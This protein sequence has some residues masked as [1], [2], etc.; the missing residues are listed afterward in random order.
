M[1]LKKLGLVLGREQFQ[2]FSTH[3]QVPTAFVLERVVR[4]FY[5]ARNSRGKSFTTFVDLDRSNPLE[6]VYHHKKP[7]FD[8]GKPGTFDEDGVMPSEILP[9]AGGIWL[10]YSGWNQKVSTPYHNSMGL[11]FSADQGRT[12]TRVYEGPIF[13]RNHLEPYVTVTPTL[14]KIGD[15][16]KMWYVSG[17][18]WLE[19]NGRREPLYVIKSAT[20]K[21]GILWQRPAL[22]VIPSKFELEAFSRPSVFQGDQNLHM[23][24]CSRGSE[25]YRDGSQGY[26]L[27]YAVSKDLGETW[28]RSD[29]SLIVDEPTGAWEDRMN[30]Y[31]YHFKLDGKHLVVYNGNG[32][33]QTGFGIGELEGVENE[34]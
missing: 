23:L 9:V 25:D 7:V 20:S 24:F 34:L 17:I 26:R 15:Q 33:G 6:V 19:V 32:F 18:R 11:A 10:Y 27:G 29:E 3:A 5:A 16:I 1:R 14:I 21:D 8:T 12:F 2:D 22:Q 28:N 31:P 13:E 4:V 30:C